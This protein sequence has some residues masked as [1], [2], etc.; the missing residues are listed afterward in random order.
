MASLDHEF[1][2]HDHC[3]P[4]WCKA[5]QD[6]VNT[7]EIANRWMSVEKDSKKYVAL[8]QVYDDFFTESQLK[9]MYHRYTSQKNEAMNQKIARVCPKNNTFSKT[10]L[11][12][13][14]V[15]WCVCDDSLGGEKAVEEIFKEIGIKSMLSL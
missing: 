8:R 14:R 10:M 9:E 1:N 4:N 3:K 6:D 11:L 13:D 15:D 2:K 5:L 7:E 12:A